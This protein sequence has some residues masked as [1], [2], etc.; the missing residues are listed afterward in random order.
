MSKYADTVKREL[1]FSKKQKRNY[2]SS[3]RSDHNNFVNFSWYFNCK[4]N[5]K[6]FIWKAKLAKERQ[7]N[8]EIQENEKL[9]DYE[10][11][12]GE[13]VDGTRNPN[14]SGIV[15][16][17]LI[18]KDDGIFDKTNNGY[19][20]DTPTSNSYITSNNSITLKESIENF[21]YIIFE[22]DSYDTDCYDTNSS[23]YVN[24]GIKIINAESIK[25]SYTQNFDWKYGNFHTIVKDFGDNHNR[26]VFGFKDSKNIYVW[27][28]WSSVG[29]LTKIRITDIKGVKY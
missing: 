26:I 4:F 5:R 6:W 1:H 10:N 14:S 8:A 3:T 19:I 13:Y 21:N 24:P 25:K 29:V 7:E 9:G 11:K 27:S 12:I 20:F 2:I 23:F 18:N 17:S 22:A 16:K 28:S 15:V